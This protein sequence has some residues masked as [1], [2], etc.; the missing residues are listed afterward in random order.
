MLAKVSVTGTGPNDGKAGRCIFPYAK[1]GNKTE[2]V[3]PHL[4]FPSHF[5]QGFDTLL[6]E[7][8]VTSTLEFGGE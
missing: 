1:R 8:R 5:S 3:L 7:A 6:D 4:P 2:F